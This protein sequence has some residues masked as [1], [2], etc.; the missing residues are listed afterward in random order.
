MARF[1]AFNLVNVK[2]SAAGK[3][4]NEWRKKTYSLK[5]ATPNHELKKKLYEMGIN[6]YSH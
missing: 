6:P 4:I 2:L 3:Y 5:M 1:V